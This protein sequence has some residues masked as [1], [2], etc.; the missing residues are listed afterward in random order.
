MLISFSATM[1]RW[2]LPNGV[3]ATTTATPLAI[4]VNNA[5]GELPSLW[6]MFIGLHGGCIGETCSIALLLGGVYLIVRKVISWH[7]PVAYL[8]TVVV[9]ALILKQNVLYHLLS[10][11]L[12]IGAIF[13]ATDY[14]TTP[15]T[16]W[17]KVIFGMGCGLLTV[18]I[19]MWGVYPEG[20]SFA[21]LFMNIVTPYISKLT[22]RKVFGTGGDR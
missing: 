18:T 3:D 19:R 9:F 20:V 7:T 8:L 10:G 13:M 5:E 15:C 22:A 17:G 12:M 6:N 16:K 1:S 4:L 21:I 2:T 11:G 14:A